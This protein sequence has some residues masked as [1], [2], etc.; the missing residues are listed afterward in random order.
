[1]AGILGYVEMLAH[2]C[3]TDADRQDYAAKIKRNADNLTDLINDI[4]DLSKVEAGALKVECF[5]FS[6]LAELENVISLLE[7]HAQA[8]GILIETVFER[9][10]PAKVASDIK[11]CRQVLTNV[12]SNAIKFTEKGKVTITARAIRSDVPDENLLAFVVT[13]TGC[14]IPKE[15][16]SN[17][18]QPFVQADSSTTRKYGGTGLGL[19]LSRRLARALGGDLVLTQSIPDKGSVFTFTMQL[20]A[21]EVAACTT[22]PVSESTDRSTHSSRLDG[23][24]ILLAEDHADNEELITQFVTRAGATVEVAHNGAEAVALANTEPFDVILMDLQMPVMDGYAATKKLRQ[25]GSTVPIIAVTA[26]A[27]LEEKRKC[28]SA[29][30]NDFLTK[31]L[32][33]ATLIATIERLAKTPQ[34]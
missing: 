7:G 25:S 5:E 33:V 26:H 1:L 23:V 14:G 21:G 10:F 20:R 29:G 19:A 27:M 22:E 12:L 31:P 16:Q 13:D 32:D 17:L 24:R 18:F 9:P 11:R 8:K 34:G 4:L 30:F 15:A 6:P 28:L 3:K 2:Y